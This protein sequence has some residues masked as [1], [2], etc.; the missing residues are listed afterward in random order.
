LVK[1]GTMKT[2]APVNRAMSGNR[3]HGSATIGSIRRASLPKGLLAL[4]PLILALLT[5]G[6]IPAMGANPTGASLAGAE[7]AL[8]PP[9]DA[10]LREHPTA[11]DPPTDDSV[12]LYRGI[13]MRL[14]PDGRIQRRV[15]QVE[16]LLTDHAVALR[17][18]QR[19]AFDTTRQEL[20]IH[21]CRTFTRDGREVVALPRAFNLTTPER[22]ATC[23]DRT[24]LQEMVISFLGVETGCLIELDYTLRDRAP[25]RPWLEG[26]EGIGATVPIREEKVIVDLPEGMAF[27]SNMMEKGHGA[28]SPQ[29]TG[30]TGQTQIYSKRD[31]PA[32]PD[33]GGLS[34]RERVPQLI[35]STCESWEMLLAWVHQKIRTAAVADPDIN[36]WAK[37]D[38]PGGRPPLDDSQRARRVAGLIGERSI[39][40]DDPSFD[41]W[42][43]VRP[44]ARTF[45]TSCGNLLDRA[46]LAIAALDAM[47]VTARPV[48]RPSVSRVSQ[49]LPTL[50]QLDNI[51]LAVGSDF[52]DVAEGVLESR[53]DPGLAEETID[54][55]KDKLSLSALPPRRGTSFLSL[56]LR[57]DDD[58][59]VKGEAIARVGGALCR[60]L[61]S[62][63][64]KGFLEGL[65]GHYAKGASVAGYKVDAFSPDTLA[66]SFTLT[67]EGLG[68]SLGGGRR[69][70]EFPSAPGLPGGATPGG[71]SLTRTA[72]TTA[73]VLP[74]LVDEEVHVWL[75]LCSRSRPLILPPAR[76]LAGGGVVVE[77]AVG[78]DG[79]RI[80]LDRHFATS[81]RTITPA[82]YAGF[83]AAMLGR[84]DAAANAIYLE[85]AAGKE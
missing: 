27:G 14:E 17:G 23:P 58:G 85:T 37:E 43:P 2:S 63:D 16:R 4:G 38:L 56:R 62:S 64:L 1:E 24:D 30:A 7:F 75:D 40:A 18:D 70:F 61:D 35:Y 80:T 5:I 71:L 50:V 39:K 22:V 65:T 44:A 82:E 12:I 32:Y 46:A 19:V 6:V 34:E 49:L 31:I 28:D 83:R 52:I 8:G 81:Q 66:V 9:T 76:K 60:A 26:M 73:I 3:G 77:T 78:R 79:A 25:W 53:P 55:S 72:R 68:D 15:R 84:T 29:A 54:G 67:G 42:L 74:C 45:D 20:V 11:V 10:L 21:A 47:G 57:E 51:W 59:S 36:A 48:F 69:R 13:Y 33:E 41:W